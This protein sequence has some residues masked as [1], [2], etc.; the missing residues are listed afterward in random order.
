MLL[1]GA[2]GLC[3]RKCNPGRWQQYLHPAPVA[4][5][6]GK[7][8]EVL[9]VQ[10]TQ[11]MVLELIAAASQGGTGLAESFTALGEIMAAP[12]GPQLQ[13]VGA[14]LR[15]GLDW[16]AA[17]QGVDRQYWAPLRE[18]TVVGWGNGAAVQQSLQTA[19]TQVRSQLLQTSRLAAARLGTWLVFPLGLCYLPAFFLLGLLPVLLSI[20][21]PLLTGT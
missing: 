5:S 13:G 20:A 6:G 9:A 11:G 14:K 21:Q 18:A 8:A 12:H 19:A 2:L 3:W 16:E 17:W 1:A 4:A 10:M 7:Q 15:L